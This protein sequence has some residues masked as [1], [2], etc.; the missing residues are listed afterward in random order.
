MS[1]CKII[2][3]ILNLPRILLELPTWNRLKGW[4]RYPTNVHPQWKGSIIR[5]CG[6]F[7]RKI[8]D[9]AVQGYPHDYRSSKR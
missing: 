7:N 9:L 6:K 3:R 1:S 5:G 2:P 4:W 8:H